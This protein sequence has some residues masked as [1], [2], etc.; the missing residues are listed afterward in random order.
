MKISI[1]RQNVG[2]ERQT[3]KKMYDDDD[4]DDDGDCDDDDY[5]Y[6]IK[7]CIVIFC[8]RFV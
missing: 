1:I 3:F 2:W 5:S 6:I 7:V 4:D 8:T